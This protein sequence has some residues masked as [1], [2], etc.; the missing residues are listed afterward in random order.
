MINNISVYLKNEFRERD[1]GTSETVCRLTQLYLESEHDHSSSNA[2][3]W[4]LIK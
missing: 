2:T 1:L 3:A 4:K